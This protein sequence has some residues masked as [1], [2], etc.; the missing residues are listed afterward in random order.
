MLEHNVVSHNVIIFC[1][2]NGYFA[3]SNGIFKFNFLALVVSE[4]IGVSQIYIRGHTPP[5]RP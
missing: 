5:G 2:Q 3:I 1:T 4:I